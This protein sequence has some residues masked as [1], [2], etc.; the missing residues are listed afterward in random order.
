[1]NKLSYEKIAVKLWKNAPKTIGIMGYDKEKLVEKLA[2][3]A[4]KI[5]KTAY[6]NFTKMK[7][8]KLKDYESMLIKRGNLGIVNISIEE[9][10]G[11]LINSNKFKILFD[12]LSKEYPL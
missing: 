6:I 2:E 12:K 9:D 1:M 8:Y 4:A 3:S 5:K 7:N 10:M 11:Y